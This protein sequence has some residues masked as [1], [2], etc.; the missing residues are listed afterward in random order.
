MIKGHLLGH[1]HKKTVILV[2]CALLGING[3][4]IG[5]LSMQL[6]IDITEILQMNNKSGNKV[7]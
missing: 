4:Y 2:T 7:G 6:M 3:K 1:F 5:V